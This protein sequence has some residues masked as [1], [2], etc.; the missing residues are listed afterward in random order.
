[1]SKLS[2][3]K[4]KKVYFVQHHETHDQQP[5]ERVIATYSLP[6]HKITISQ[7]LKNLMN[8]RYGDPNVH[9]VFNSVDTDQFHSPIRSKNIN[10]TVGILY[11]TIPWKGCDISLEAFLIAD[12]KLSN[13]R[14]ISFGNED[15]SPQLPL[16]S[17]CQYHKNPEQNSLKDI[18]SQC[19]VWLCGSQTEGFHLPPLEA[20][21]CRC[22]V[23]STCV[24][25]PQDIIENGIN[26]Y[27]SPVGDVDALADNLI[28][29]LSLSEK[30][31][32]TL[33]QNAYKTAISYTWSDAAQLFE[34]ALYKIIG[35]I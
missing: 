10:A 23:V 17:D 34:K 7:W 14:L 9:L 29:V 28:K 5:K 13:L 20:M 30:N 18:Y 27:L 11:S 22:P 31:W 3:S 4:G 26:G 19:D 15:I 25:G 35:C 8:T 16:P 24:G 12:Q 32:Q 33:S 21:A 6:L 1:M 2:P